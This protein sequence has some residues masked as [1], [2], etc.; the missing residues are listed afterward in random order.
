MLKKFWLGETP[1]WFNFW[2]LGVLFFRVLFIGLVLGLDALN[3]NPE[4]LMNT[5]SFITIPLTLF[6]AVGT[7]RSA[8]NYKGKSV[9]SILTELY[10]IITIA[11]LILP[12]AY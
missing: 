2:I 12:Y 9:W 8:M 5:I 6:W 10:I 4:F 11:A 7:W 3:F 1:M